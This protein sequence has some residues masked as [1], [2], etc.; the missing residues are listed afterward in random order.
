MAGA[1]LVDGVDISKIGLR[2]LRSNIAIIPQV[3]LSRVWHSNSLYV[4]VADIAGP[5]AVLGHCA[6]QPGPLQCLFGRCSLDR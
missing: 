4:A 3:M 1:M 6:Q 5:C 2:D